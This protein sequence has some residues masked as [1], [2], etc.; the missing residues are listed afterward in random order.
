MVQY[1]ADFE[2]QICIQKSVVENLIQIV[3]CAAQ[4]M[5]EPGDGATV[6]R[7]HFLD[8]MAK[9]ETVWEC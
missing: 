3:A 9:M 4:F 8:A 2:K 7:Q 1:I 6:S 5:G